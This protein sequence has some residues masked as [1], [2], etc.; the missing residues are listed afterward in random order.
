MSTD[1]NTIITKLNSQSK[2]LDQIGVKQIEHD[3]KFDQIDKKLESHDKR[4]DQMDK[5]FAD[6]DKKFIKNDKVHNRIMKKLLEHD[7]EFVKVRQEIKEAVYDSRDEILEVLDGLVKE[8]KD[9]K[10][11]KTALGSIV[12]RHETDI[13]KIKKVVKIA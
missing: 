6:H 13:L 5:K 12:S 7:D 3:K 2:K 4:F 9:S 8:T 11:E 1:E 10:I